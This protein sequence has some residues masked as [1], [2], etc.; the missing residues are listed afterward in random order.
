LIIFSASGG[1]HDADPVLQRFLERV[2]ARENYEKLSSSDGTGSFDQFVSSSNVVSLKP[3]SSLNGSNSSATSSG[4]EMSCVPSAPSA[5]G[6]GQPSADLA[7]A[8]RNFPQ[9]EKAPA[10][11]PVSSPAVPSVS[12]PVKP[13]SVFEIE[14]KQSSSVTASTEQV[15]N[16]TISTTNQGAPS[17]DYSE[18]ESDLDTPTD[19]ISASSEPMDQDS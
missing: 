16:L 11:V 7:R 10:S 8:S 2:S 5:V 1:S 19:P 12:T 9:S 14:T 17:N 3:P 4:S 18:G 15:S 13:A 6:S